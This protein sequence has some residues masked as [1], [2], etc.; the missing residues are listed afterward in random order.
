MKKAIHTILA[1]LAVLA[2]GVA[3]NVP[4]TRAAEKGA[5]P[6]VISHGAK[7]T[8]ADN[9]SAGNITVFDFSSKYCP[10]CMALSPKLDMLHTKIPNLVVVK[11]DINRPSIKGIDWKSP[12]AQ[13]FKLHEIPHI[14][15]Y[16]AD[17]KLVA[18]SDQAMSLIQSAINLMSGK[19]GPTPKLQRLEFKKDDDRIALFFHAPGDMT[20]L[21]STQNPPTFKNADAN[22]YVKSYSAYA[23]EILAACNA[24]DSAKI[25]AL[26]ANLNDWDAKSKAIL[27]NLKGDGAM[28]F[29]KWDT[30]VTDEIGDAIGMANDMIARDMNKG[31]KGVK[32]SK[33]KGGKKGKARPDSTPTPPTD[34]ANAEN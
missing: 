19:Y 13:Q 2:L 10:P 24:K 3:A 27:K 31:K 18:Q 20:A 21:P 15:I 32:G 28:K 11:V 30:W 14:K 9:L 16:D 6:A 34:A 12:V 17:G 5:E 1:I 4:V 33:G 8:L 22:E 25:Q 7:V 26:G 29:L 23:N